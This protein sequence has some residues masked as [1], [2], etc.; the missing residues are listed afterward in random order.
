VSDARRD[1]LEIF[2]AAVS[3][4]NGRM[5]VFD[6]LTAHPLT[7]PVHLIAVGKAAAAMALGAHERLG[8]AIRAA[9]IVT[10]YGA[11]ESLPWP[12]IEAGHPL[13]DAASLEAG[14]QLLAFIARLPRRAP[15]L[16]LL[17]GGASALVEVLP[18]GISLATLQAINRWL[19]ASGLDIAACNRL[20]KHLSLIKGGRLAKFLYPRPVLCLAI[21][22]VPGDDP[23]TIGS[24]PLAA[25]TDLSSP[26]TTAGLPE[27]VAAALK[28]AVP[29][30]RPDDEC[31]RDVR[32]ETIATLAE[33][34]Q[35]AAVTA[36][37]LGYPVMLDS[38]FIAGDTLAAGASLARQLLES[39]FGVVHIW[40]GE[41]TLSLPASPGRGGR[42]QSLAL[43]AALSLQGRAH[44]WFLAA[45]TDGSDGP[46][47][48]A[49]AIVDGATVER[50]AAADL[51]AGTAL[52]R[53]DAGT[54]LE[55]SG[56]LIHTGPT[57][58]NVMD[59]MLGL[60]NES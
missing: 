20:R 40:G 27:F 53:A 14:Q 9:F 43:S 30:P 8:A 35:A 2:H 29:A 7:G 34:K 47:A 24:G 12:V 26:P 58:T 23:R 19:L 22:D 44:V 21:S 41:T 25:D 56:D 18:A 33:A 50:G 46:T 31:F 6:W 11:S 5:R 48:D 59:L 36:R 3:A 4:V 52:A 16:V 51:D 57:G 32:F 17:S 39:A 54:F 42:N 49:G 38:G 28:Q 13:P 10:K 45:G 15:V 1:L 60:K 55:A 37:R